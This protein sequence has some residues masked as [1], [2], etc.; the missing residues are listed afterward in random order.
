MSAMLRCVAVGVTIF[1]AALPDTLRG[2][3]MTLVDDSMNDQVADSREAVVLDSAVSSAKSRQH[4]LLESVILTARHPFLGVG[5]GMF[6]V[7]EDALAQENGMRKGSW[8][9]THNSYTQI[10][11]EVGVPALIF[12]LAALLGWF[13]DAKRIYQ[14]T[15][16][17][18][19]HREFSAMALCLMLMLMNFIVTAAFNSGAYMNYIAVLG[20]ITAAAVRAKSTTGTSAATAG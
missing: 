5:P 16:G 19:E 7:A 2:R 18:P 20:G 1:Y 6:T 11:S 10:S 15:R 8:L 3:Y 17:S 4:M 9:E 13:W 14:A 12:Y